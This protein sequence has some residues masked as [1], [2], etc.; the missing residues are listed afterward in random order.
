[1]DVELKTYLT[2]RG[3][4]I[5]KITA[6]FQ[7]TKFL[8]HSLPSPDQGLLHKQAIGAE[9]Q[10]SSSNRPHGKNTSYLHQRRSPRGLPRAPN[11]PL[12]FL[13]N[14]KFCKDGNTPCS[15]SL[16][17]FTNYGHNFIP[18]TEENYFCVYLMKYIEQTP[19][20]GLRLTDSLVQLHQSS[21]IVDRTYY[22]SLQG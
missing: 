17:L 1:M 13:F 22:S 19:S 18:V 12:L 16:Y 11:R 4:I 20:Y 9:I 2:R 8:L 10:R 3:S 6:R 14:R 15:F 7:F 21:N 5:V